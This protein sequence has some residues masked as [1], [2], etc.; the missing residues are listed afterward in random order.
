MEEFGPVQIMVV[1]FRETNF[2]GRV[3][4]ELKRLKELD[5][6][7]LVDLVV[8]TKDDAGDDPGRGAQST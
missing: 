8:V 2:Q 4:A 7:R 6:V 3:L 5:I 1:G